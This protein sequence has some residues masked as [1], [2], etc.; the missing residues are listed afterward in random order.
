MGNTEECGVWG[1]SCWV[2]SDQSKVWKSGSRFRR[3]S[4]VRVHSL[5]GFE[6]FV[7]NEATMLECSKVAFL[8][9]PPFVMLELWHFQPIHVVAYA[10][11]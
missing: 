10:K 11:G 6:N 5:A 3:D 7:V 9:D 2:I 8:Y 4:D 1:L